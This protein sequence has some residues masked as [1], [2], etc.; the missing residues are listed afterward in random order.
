MKIDSAIRE[1]TEK[2]DRGAMQ[3]IEHLG[4]DYTLNITD[5]KIDLFT[6]KEGFDTFGR[7]LKD[8]A[9]VMCESV[10]DTGMEIP[11]HEATINSVSRFIESSLFK[12]IKVKYR[13]VPIFV[14]SYIS[15]ISKLDQE[16]DNVKN[17]M[18][19]A[20]V[21]AENI[22]LV[23]EFCDIFMDRLNESF[24][25]SMDKILWASGYNSNKRLRA[26]AKGKIT[27]D[28]HVFL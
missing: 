20:G 6:I 16:I 19:E 25:K 13:D 23:N 22:G 15:G 2:Y 12:D 24:G 8:Y 18:S 14:E 17:Q 28:K 26:V 7:Y 21:P 3:S 9:K 1:F 4:R 27:T 10:A 5:Q 11:S